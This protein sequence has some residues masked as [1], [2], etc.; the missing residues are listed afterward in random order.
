MIEDQTELEIASENADFCSQ[1]ERKARQQ[2]QILMSRQRE[3]EN[4]GDWRLVNHFAT[5]IEYQKQKEQTWAMAKASIETW[6]YSGPSNRVRQSCPE[7][8]DV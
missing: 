6:V 3:A 8:P 1:M 7:V 2:Q 5:A 4:V